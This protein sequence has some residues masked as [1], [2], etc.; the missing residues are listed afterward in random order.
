LDISY[1]RTC[2][3]NIA[4]AMNELIQYVHTLEIR[5]ASHTSRLNRIVEKLERA[6]NQLRCVPS[7]LDAYEQTN[8]AGRDWVTST[9]FII[10]FPVSRVDIG[11]IDEL[12]SDVKLARHGGISPQAL[13]IWANLRADLATLQQF[14]QQL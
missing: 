12:L 13:E 9:L 4:S 3:V 1:A 10:L 11:E 2:A 7:A 6:A 8:G 14:L 5:Y